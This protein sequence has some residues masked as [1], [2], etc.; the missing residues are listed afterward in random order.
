MELIAQILTN[1]QLELTIARPMVHIKTLSDHSAA[2]AM[3]DTLAT[4]WIARTLLNV[5][6]A[7]TTVMSMLLAPT[8]TAF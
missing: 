7:L 4:V 6:L 3:L 2:L 1:V 5:H 8:M